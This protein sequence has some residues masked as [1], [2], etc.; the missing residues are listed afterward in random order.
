MAVAEAISGNINPEYVFSR[1]KLATT[2]YVGRILTSTGSIKVRNINQKN[3]FLAGNL[4]KTM[5]KADVNEIA[6][7]P[8]AIP[9]ATIVV[10]NNILATEAEVCPLSP[11]IKALL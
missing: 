11:S 1:P 10:L 6:I 8:T 4:K 9:V 5:A 2:S 7:L 3:K